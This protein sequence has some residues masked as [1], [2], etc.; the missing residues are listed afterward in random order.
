MS[1]A[2]T[3]TLPAQPVDGTFD[4]VPLGGDGFIAPH[5]MYVLKAIG[6][7]CDAGGGHAEVTT[8]FD[9][10]YS[11]L[12]GSFQVAMVGAGASVLFRLGLVDEKLAGIQTV[13]AT[14][15]DGQDSVARCIWN[16]TPFFKAGGIKVRAPNVD[17]DTLTL[18]AI[19]YN[20]DK[21]ASEVV[22]LSQLLAATP[23][24]GTLI[25]TA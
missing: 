25:G 8:T 20:F 7:D 19:I 14:G 6:V 22:P 15:I 21:R 12:V 10:R 9:V 5:S 18:S 3:L 17:G 13:N 16:P 4:L 1:V 24:S 2:V 23:R 11:S